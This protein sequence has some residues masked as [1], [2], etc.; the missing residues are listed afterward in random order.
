[1]V[2][3]YLASYTALLRIWGNYCCYFDFF[4]KPCM[5]EFAHLAQLYLFRGFE[6]NWNKETVIKLGQIL[7]PTSISWEFA[8]DLAESHLSNSGRLTLI[9][10][11]TEK[12]SRL[13]PRNTSSSPGMSLLE[14]SRVL[15]FLSGEQSAL[16]IS[17]QNSLYCILMRK[18]KC[19]HD[20]EI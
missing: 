17:K 7:L 15:W 8:N 4:S 3:K 13:Q 11:L 18:V 6:L 12:A 19:I 10:Y 1:M 16:L 14:T 9:L 20:R 2:Q 5:H